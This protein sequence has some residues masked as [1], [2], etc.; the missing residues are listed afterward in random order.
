MFF[1]PP[2]AIG[3][4]PTPIGPPAELR[5]FPGSGLRN[6][7]IGPFRSPRFVMAERSSRVCSATWSQD[8]CKRTA[9][10]VPGLASAGDGDRRGMQAPV[11]TRPSK[12]PGTSANPRSG[13]DYPIAFECPEFT[14]L[15]PMTGQPDFAT[16][17]IDYV[18]EALCVELKSLKLY[19]LSY[20]D[21]GA[22]HE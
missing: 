10:K 14:C 11:T 5:R 12:Q 17:L 3:Q 4:S 22:L 21:D 9:S 13:R 2:L 18:P 8:H 6:G 7:H 1:F 20:R 19:L 15:C 16:I